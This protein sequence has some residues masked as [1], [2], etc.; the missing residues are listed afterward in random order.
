MTL[1]SQL[2][3]SNSLWLFFCSSKLFPQWEFGLEQIQGSTFNQLPYYHDHDGYVK[4]VLPSYLLLQKRKAD[5]LKS[6]EFAMGIWFGAN[7]GQYI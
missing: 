1:K 3:I 5:P 7:T 4:V 6:F 2:I